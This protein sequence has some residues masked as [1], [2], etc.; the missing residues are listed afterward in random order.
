MIMNNCYPDFNIIIKIIGF[1]SR[2]FYAKPNLYKTFY[3]TYYLSNIIAPLEQKGN[4]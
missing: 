1:T 3:E 4:K 2:F